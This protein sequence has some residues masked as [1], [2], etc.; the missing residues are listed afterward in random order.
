MCSQGEV[1]SGS[2][3]KGTIGVVICDLRAPGSI[4]SDAGR[5]RGS[6]AEPRATGGAIQTKVIDAA[7]R[8]RASKLLFLGSNCHLP[9]RGSTAH[10]GDVRCAH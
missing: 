8:S 3:V 6:V 5:E 9:K 1:A 4:T 7:Y 2:A 10:A